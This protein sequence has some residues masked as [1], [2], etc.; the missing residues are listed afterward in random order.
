M[1]MNLQVLTGCRKVR[2]A[3]VWVDLA[4]ELPEKLP[5]RA[6]QSDGEAVQEDEPTLLVEVSRSY[7]FTFIQIH[8][9]I[10]VHYCSFYTVV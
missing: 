4:S 2:F 5:T 10:M 9:C 1:P 8:Y 7:M 3:D 6:F